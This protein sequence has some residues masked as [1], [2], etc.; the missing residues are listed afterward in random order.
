MVAYILSPVSLMIAGFHGN[1]DGVLAAAM[2]LAAFSCYRGQVLRSALYLALACNIKVA[3]L[4]AAPVL[5]FHWWHLGNA[6]KFFIPAAAVILLGWSIPLVLCPAEF[7]RK[8]IGYPGYWGIWGFTGMLK[9]TGIAAFQTSDFTQ[10]ESHQLLIMQCSKWAIVACSMILGWR[11]RH[12]DVLLPLAMVWAVF[13]VA[14]SGVA[15]QYLIWPAAI[16]FLALPRAWMIAT[17]GSSVFLATFYTVLCG[18]LPWYYGEAN[19]TVNQGWLPWSNVAWA[20]WIGAL[21]LLIIE[22]RKKP[23]APATAAMLQTA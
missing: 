14:A 23:S 7:Y 6:R 3:A 2:A 12:R 18:G 1:V 20:G 22:A 11:M 4:L 9:A 15:A 8:V 19:E 21:A 10:L 16:V 5:F 13:M 17:L